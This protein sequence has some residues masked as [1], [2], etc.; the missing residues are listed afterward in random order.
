MLKKKFVGFTFFILLL[1]ALLTYQGVKGESRFIDFPLY[2]LKLLEQGA[3]TVITGIKNIF[4]SYFRIVGKEEEN[5]KLLAKINRL[6]EEK[7]RII[8]AQLENIRLRSLLQLKS[9]RSDYITSAEVFARDSTNWFQILWIDKGKK[10]GIKKNMVAVTA[11]G[12]VGRVHKVLDGNA[13]II[14]LTDVNSS[15]AVTLQ[16]SRAQ[17]ILDGRGDKR[18]YLKYISKDVEVQPGEIVVTSGLEGIYP[19]GLVVGSVE[20]VDKNEEEVFQLI[21]VV[22]SQDFNTLEEV[23]ILKR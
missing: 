14:L 9:E 17:G 13:N 22:P 21:E 8:E 18:C 4:G 15:I 20:N 10:D 16:T 11:L 23:A 7:N 5:R 12:P 6:E 3:T 2:P 1:L 19:P